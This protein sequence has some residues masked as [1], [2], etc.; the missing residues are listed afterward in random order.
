M[1][2]DRRKFYK[3][4]RLSLTFDNRDRFELYYIVNYNENADLYAIVYFIYFYIFGFTSI[5][6]TNH[7]GSKLKTQIYVCL[8]AY[9]CIFQ[10][11]LILKQT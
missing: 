11:I 8:L 1:S 6:F 2:Y 10:Q 4:V 5:I 7:C 9:V 3:Q